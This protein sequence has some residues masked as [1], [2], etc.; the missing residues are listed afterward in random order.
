[1]CCS[2]LTPVALL[3]LSAAGND[4]VTFSGR[5]D[6]FVGARMNFVIPSSWL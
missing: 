6:V 1:M 3:G 5:A 4:D 2:F